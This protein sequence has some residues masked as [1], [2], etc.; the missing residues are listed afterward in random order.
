MIP[1]AARGIDLLALRPRIQPSKTY[2]LDVA[3]G[4]IRGTV[5]DLEA[6]KQAV[7][8]ILNTE[9]YGQLIYSWNYAAELR[10]LI[11]KPHEL[12]LPEVKRLIAEALTQD[13]RITGVDGFAF[14]QCRAAVRVSFVVH[15][16]F[17]TFDTEREVAV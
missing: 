6:V 12:V 11:G 5:D 4:R 17:G 1:S 2:A 14:E 13:D 3:Q 16:I 8:L 15:T 9:R 10:G 7:Y